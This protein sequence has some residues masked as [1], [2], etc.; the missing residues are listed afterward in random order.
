MVSSASAADGRRFFRLFSLLPRHAEIVGPSEDRNHA[1]RRRTQPPLS[2]PISQFSI[3]FLQPFSSFTWTYVIIIIIIIIIIMRGRLRAMRP[4]VEPVTV[5][6]SSVVFSLSFSPF[7][8]W[9]WQ[10]PSR[11]L[12]VAPPFF[13]GSARRWAG[14]L[15]QL[16]AVRSLPSR[17][18]RIPV[19]TAAVAIA[20]VGTA[21]QHADHGTLGRFLCSFSLNMSLD[22]RHAASYSAYAFAALGWVC[23]TPRRRRVGHGPQHQQP[24]SFFLAFIWLAR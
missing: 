9:R 8:V 4:S 13:L 19:T 16:C 18:P 15:Q 10:R 20:F 24:R 7:A 2:F 6:S 21:P 5:P 14:P 23:A 22:A 3:L 12:G 1:R 11:F 17:F